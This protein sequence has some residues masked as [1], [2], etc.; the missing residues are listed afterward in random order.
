MFDA[1]I[2]PL[3]DPPLNRLG[4]WLAACGV[5]ANAVTV[6]GF[7]IGM[8]A[9]PAI[10]GGAYWLA[11]LLIVVSRLSDGIDGAVARATQTTDFGGFLDIVLD[12]IFYAAIPLAFAIAEPDA[13]A[14][15]AAVLLMSFFANGS[16]FLAY[17][18]VAAKRGETTRAQGV[19]SLY[20]VAG[21][22]EGFETIVFLVAITLLPSA[23]VYLAYAYAAL[24]TA[25]AIG[26]IL[27]AAIAFNDASDAVPVE[28]PSDGTTVTRPEGP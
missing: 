8:L 17:A 28:A 24:C 19:K 23:F 2:R 16:A 9:V 20:Y 18:I 26:R 10:L 15:A 27:L 11:V 22:A 1:R 13:N 7:A 14:L 25:S 4:R 5:T 12:F 21:L 6:A 3:I